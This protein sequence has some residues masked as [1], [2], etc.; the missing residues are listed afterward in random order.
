MR[1]KIGVLLSGCGVFDGSEIH[2]ATLTLY[3]L[4]R[5]KADVIP[6]APD[7][8]QLHVINHNT[9]DEM[10]ETRNVRTESAR[11]ARGEVKKLSS[12]SIDDID[13]L[14]I[15]GGFG[16]AKNLINYAVKGR[17]CTIDPNVKNLINQVIQSKKPLGTM[18]IAPV[19]VAVALKDTD[20]H[21]VLTIGSDDSTASD[22]EF[23]KAKHS[24]CSVDQ[25]AVDKENRIVSTPAYMLGPGIADIAKG[26]EKLVKKIV[27]LL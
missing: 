16:A 2:E 14:I 25:I 22:I 6:I 1:K 7:K 4:D 8:E 19:V 18:C 27:E 20:I 23:F 17:D 9:S 21:P 11:I 13:A 12:I 10:Q 26:I 15:P 3:F 24:K 5:E